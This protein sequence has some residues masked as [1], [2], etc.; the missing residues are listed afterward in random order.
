MPTWKID[1]AHSTANFSVKHM[2]IT[3]V[4]GRFNNVEGSIHFDPDNPAAGSVEATIDVAS[5]N[6][7][8]PDRDNHLRSADFFDVETY[9]TITFKSTN[10]DVSGDDEAT[11][12]GELTMHGVTKTVTLDVE[13][14]GE[15]SNPMSGDRTIGFEASTKLNREEFG[16]NWNVALESGGV[17]VGKDVK[18]ALDIQAVL[19]PETEA[20]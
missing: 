12:T 14:L 13:Y 2:M 6:T 15:S 9:P 3:T 5:I 19:V 18:V 1:T 8:A 11:I 16:L 4:R 10:I 17:L 20:V 7:N